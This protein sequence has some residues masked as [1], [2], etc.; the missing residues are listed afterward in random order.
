MGRAR[1]G[2]VR[3]ETLG[4]P[5]T[6]ISGMVWVAVAFAGMLGF[7]RCFGSEKDDRSLDGLLLLPGDRSAVLVGKT[8]FNLA[9]L[10]AVEALV[11]P[12]AGLFFHPPEWG[13]AILMLTPVLFLGTLGYAVAGTLFAA[14]TSNTRLRDLLLPILLLPV[15]VPV[16]IASVEGTAM[17][18]QAAS[19]DSVL[20]R[21]ESLVS[22]KGWIRVLIACDVIYI[23]AALWLFEPVV[24]E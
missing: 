2:A 18:V 1:S 19:T 4:G 23:A 15:A 20:V 16:L 10:F 3:T 8:L 7:G 22:M 11:L 6:L 17:A 5:E 24:E 12:L 14:I 13:C 9:L 21:Q